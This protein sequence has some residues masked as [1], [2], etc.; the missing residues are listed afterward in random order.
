MLGRR[1]G[2]NWNVAYSGRAK[3]TPVAL[4]F[5]RNPHRF[6]IV[7]GKF[8]C[9]AALGLGHFA[10]Q[11][12]GVESA[13]AARIAPAEIVG[14]QRAPSGTDPDATARVPFSP[15]QEIGGASEIAGR[16][17][18]EKRAAKICVQ[19]KYLIDVQCVGCNDQFVLWFTA[20]CLQPLDVFIASD[21]RVLTV[22]A[23]A[24]PV[25]SPIWRV[26]QVSGSMINSAPS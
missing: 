18:T 19:A 12:D 9:R 23:L 24:G 3:Y 20:A 21:I 5:G 15:V 6:R 14:Q 26:P 22:D 25:R 2:Y 7:V 8:Y 16:C 13:I 10:D 17:A 1:S 11:A 4:D